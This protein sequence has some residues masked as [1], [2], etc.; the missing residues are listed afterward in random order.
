M[1]KSAPLSVLVFATI[2][3]GGSADAAMFNLGGMMSGK[4]QNVQITYGSRTLQVSAG[5]VK[6]RLNGGPTMDSYC[7]DLDHWG[8]AGDTYAVNIKPMNIQGPN[9]G[10]AAWL[11]NTYAAGVNSTAKGAALQLAIW[12]VIADNGDGFNAGSLKSSISGTVRTL[13]QSYILASQG[14][15][16]SANWLEATGH[17]RNNDKNQNFM[18]VPEPTSVAAIAIGVLSIFRARRKKQAA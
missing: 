10:R 1:N 12:D 14:H 8:R 11:F 16:G 13:A 9:G 3:G 6:G 4:F 15:V 2:A 17:G 5:A 18:A 7:V